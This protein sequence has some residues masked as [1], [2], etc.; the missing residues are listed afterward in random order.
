MT[1]NSLYPHAT[2]RFFQNQSGLS[3]LNSLFPA[4]FGLEQ[5]HF[6]LKAGA[7]PAPADIVEL[8]TRLSRRGLGV[9]SKPTDGTA[10]I[11]A[12]ETR[13]G[14]LEIKPDGFTHVLEVAFLPLQLRQNC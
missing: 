2:R 7:A 1:G 13:S 9:Y 3:G 11:V 4:S 10:G 5:E 12:L 14:R 8:F 6:I